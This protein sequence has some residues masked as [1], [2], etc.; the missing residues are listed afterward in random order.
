VVN[1]DFHKDT[2]SVRGAR[3]LRPSQYIWNQI[4][5]HVIRTFVLLR[6]FVKLSRLICSRNSGQ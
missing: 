3:L 5:P 4:P 2:N 6:L 1:K